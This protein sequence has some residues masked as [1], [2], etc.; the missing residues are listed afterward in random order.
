MLYHDYWSYKETWN[1]HNV[2]EINY[3]KKK[4][5]VKVLQ[6]LGPFPHGPQ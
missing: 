5:E 1:V 6:G 3:C 2:Y 4:D